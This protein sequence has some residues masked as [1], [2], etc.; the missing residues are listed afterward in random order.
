MGFVTDTT[1]VDFDEARMMGLWATSYEL[2]ARSWE[3]QD[4]KLKTLGM[5]QENEDR[6]EDQGPGDKMGQSKNTRLMCQWLV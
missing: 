2:W 5:T 1:T 3:R 4:E 6:D